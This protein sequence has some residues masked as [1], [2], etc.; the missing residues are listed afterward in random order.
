MIVIKTKTAINN[1]YMCAVKHKNNNQPVP[2]EKNQVLMMER[3]SLHR[4][5][6]STLLDTLQCQTWQGSAESV[7]TQKNTVLGLYSTLLPSLQCQRT[8]PGTSTRYL[9]VLRVFLHRKTL[10]LVPTI[11]PNLLCQTLGCQVA[12]KLGSSVEY[13]CTYQ[14]QSIA[15]ELIENHGY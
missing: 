13:C 3:V 10:Y 15:N 5:T 11:L 2:H 6:L 1:Q 4:K 7:F 8:L 9:V 12:F 14:P